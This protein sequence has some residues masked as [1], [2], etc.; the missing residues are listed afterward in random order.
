MYVPSPNQDESSFNYDQS[1]Y[2][3]FSILGIINT[4]FSFIRFY[5]YYLKCGAMACVSWDH[6]EYRTTLTNLLIK[7]IIVLFCAALLILSSIC[8]L[9]LGSI[10]FVEYSTLLTIEIVN[11]IDKYKSYRPSS[12]LITLFQQI[13]KSQFLHK[14]KL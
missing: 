3:S 10:G 9:I 12:V 4:H 13:T 5:T 2:M 11:N 1:F 7:S 14:F 8:F 6:I